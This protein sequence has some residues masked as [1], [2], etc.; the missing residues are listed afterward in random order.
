L[1]RP[2]SPHE[3][4]KNNS[5]DRTFRYVLCPLIRGWM[6]TSEDRTS[7]YVPCPLTRL[8]KPPERIGHRYVLCTSYEYRSETSKDRTPRYVLYPLRRDGGEHQR[9][10]DISAYSVSPHAKLPFLW[11]ETCDFRHE[12]LPTEIR[13]S[14]RTS[15]HR[16]RFNPSIEPPLADQASILQP[17][18]LADRSPHCR[19]KRQLAARNANLRTALRLTT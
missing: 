13:P 14:D 19:T 17:P 9:G 18:L 7:R 11:G 1:V 8:D 15:A 16:S 2:V 12:G 4:G 3:T 10:K 5:E 6:E